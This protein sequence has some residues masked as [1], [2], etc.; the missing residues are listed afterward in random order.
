M[1]TIYLYEGNVSGIVTSG[2]VVKTGENRS[3]KDY[4]FQ[5]RKYKIILTISLRTV[6]A[7]MFKA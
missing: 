1:V 2:F 5:C 4:F 3:I 7:Y 6:H